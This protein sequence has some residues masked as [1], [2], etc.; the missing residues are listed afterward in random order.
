MK[1]KFI[2]F[3]HSMGLGKSF[4]LNKWAIEQYGAVET[5]NPIQYQSFGDIEQERIEKIISDARAEAARELKIRQD[6]KIADLMEKVEAL[7]DR[8]LT[9]D[10]RLEMDRLL[11]GIAFYRTVNGV[12]ERLDPLTVTTLYDTK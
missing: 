4:D 9:V 10:E 6:K 7:S 1:N 8:P 2:R 12:K 3:L 5:P 11:F